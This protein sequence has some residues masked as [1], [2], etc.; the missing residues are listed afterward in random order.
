MADLL[1]AASARVLECAA[2]M[3]AGYRLRSAG[4]LTD[5]DAE[6]RGRGSIAFGISCLD[7]KN[8]THPPSL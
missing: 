4:T 6:V 1:G 8:T 2:L 7:R 3:T 5:G